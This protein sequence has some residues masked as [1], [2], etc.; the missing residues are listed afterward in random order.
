MTSEC[1]GCIMYSEK[2]E[3][4][5]LIPQISDTLKCPCLKCLIKMMCESDCED[6][7]VYSRLPDHLGR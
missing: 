4:C 6:Y 1:K 3:K 5:S 2:S 7:Q